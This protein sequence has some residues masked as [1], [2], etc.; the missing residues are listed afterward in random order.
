MLMCKVLDCSREAVYEKQQVCQ[1]HYFRYMRYGTYDLTRK[2]AK[3]RIMTPNGYYKVYEPTYTRINPHNGYVWEHRKVLYDK[4]GD[5]VP[6]CELCGKILT[7]ETCQTDHIDEDKTNNKPDNLR[8]TCVSCNTNRNERV[9]PK[10][11]LDGK[12][13]TISQWSKE[14]GVTCCRANIMRR[15]LRGMSFR[16]ALYAK[17]LTH[18][19]DGYTREFT[20][21][22]T[23]NSSKI[24]T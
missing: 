4:H 11:E 3:Y 12:V 14:P 20:C 24:R 23:K 5:V 18:P 9:F 17:N 13:L 21:F 7:W 2:K 6:P 19:R 22:L 16:D 1:K 10:Y 8:P 15:L